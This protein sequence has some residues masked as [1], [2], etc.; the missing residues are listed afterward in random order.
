[1]AKCRQSSDWRITTDLQSANRNANLPIGKQ[2][3]KRRNSRKTVPAF[4]FYQLPVVPWL[5]SA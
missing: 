3:N 4:V 5:L 1:L 2:K